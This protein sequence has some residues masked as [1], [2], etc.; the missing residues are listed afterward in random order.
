MS[1]YNQRFGPYALQPYGPTLLP[2]QPPMP[3]Q[4]PQ[5]VLPPTPPTPPMQKPPVYPGRSANQ[6]TAQ[7]IRGLAGVGYADPTLSNFGTAGM[8]AISALTGAMN[9]AGMA[10]GAG[11]R[12][13]LGRPISPMGNLTGFGRLDLDLLNSINSPIAAAAQAQRAR[14]FSEQGRRDKERGAR[15]A[16]DSHGQ[17]RGGGTGSR[18]GGIVAGGPR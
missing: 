3:T 15:G 7:D 8:N 12:G 17:V 16:T 6:P 1:L 13:L 9:P 18:G 4:P 11:V 10:I 14:A 2:P 5:M